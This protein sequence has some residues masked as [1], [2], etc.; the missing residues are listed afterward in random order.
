MSWFNKVLN[1]FKPTTKELWTPRIGFVT[2]G[3]WIIHTGSGQIGRVKTWTDKAIVMTIHGS[4]CGHGEDQSAQG[5]D[6]PDNCHNFRIAGGEEVDD[7]VN[8]IK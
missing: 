1:S 3:L 7:Y 8:G 6:L 5:L 4:T 2:P